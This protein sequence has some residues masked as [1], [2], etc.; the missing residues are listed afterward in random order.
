MFDDEPSLALELPAERLTGTV[1]L[2]FEWEN[3]EL[4]HHW[5]WMPELPDKRFPLP[6]LRLGYHRLRLWAVAKP[7]LELA[8]DA[9]LIVC[10]RRAR[11]IDER[12]AGLAVT[13]Y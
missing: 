7:E 6:A 3:G 5:F 9:R 10:P 1:K 11:T 12:V 8:F 13:L 4:E 2:E